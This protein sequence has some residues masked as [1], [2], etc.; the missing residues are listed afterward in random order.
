MFQRYSKILNEI[1][2]GGNLS[3]EQSALRD[4]AGSN[5]LL[6]LNKEFRARMEEGYDNLTKKEKKDLSSLSNL[7]RNTAENFYSDIANG[8]VEMHDQRDVLEQSSLLQAKYNHYSSMG[9]DPGDMGEAVQITQ[10]HPDLWGN[11]EFLN[12]LQSKYDSLP[13]GI[14]DLETVKVISSEIVQSVKDAKLEIEEKIDNK[15]LPEDKKK[16]SKVKN[17]GKK[18]LDIAAHSSSISNTGSIVYTST[19]LAMGGNPITLGPAIAFTAGAM[20]YLSKK[21]LEIERLENAKIQVENLGK[22]N[23]VIESEQKE[24][25]ALNTIELQSPSHMHEYRDHTDD[26][27]KSLHND[28]SNKDT[29][30]TFSKRGIS[31]KGSSVVKSSLESGVP[32]SVMNYANIAVSGASIAA[33]AASSALSAASLPSTVAAIYTRSQKRKD[34]RL[35]NDDRVAQDNLDNDTLMTINKEQ[36]DVLRKYSTQRQIMADTMTSLSVKAEGDKELDDLLKKE[37][38]SGDE[39]RTITQYYDE[40]IC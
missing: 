35:S 27:T 39:K 10:Q 28:S 32:K 1:S 37:T 22:A 6:L 25:P 18:A 5:P 20:A 2:R 40:C 13:E 24:N 34:I 7:Y 38:L 3:P 15:D 26:I 19:M 21:E 9:E 17:F 8:E 14:S 11:F 29:P 33:S 12:R 30:R 4:A 23:R 36:L 31:R 16:S